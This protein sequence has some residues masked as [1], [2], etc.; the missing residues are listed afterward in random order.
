VL[1]VARSIADLGGESAL[2]VAHIAEAIQ[3]RRVLAQ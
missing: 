3:N 1:R 2:Q